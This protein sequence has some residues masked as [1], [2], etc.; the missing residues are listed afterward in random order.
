[1]KIKDLIEKYKYY[2][3]AVL[4]GIALMLISFPE[5]ESTEVH[6]VENQLNIRDEL[7]DV[8]SDIH[9]AGRVSVM[10]TT[11]TSVENRYLQDESITKD[12]LKL[13]QEV[14][15]ILVSK[16]GGGQEPIKIQDIYPLYKGALIVC[17]GGENPVVQLQIVKAVTS[18]LGISSDKITI[19]KMKE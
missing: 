18:L 10:I 17:D 4:V 13:D 11:Y 1:M 12:D 8:L 6:I 7:E 15:T 3:I 19:T 14:E 2:C 16:Q 9:G 5:N